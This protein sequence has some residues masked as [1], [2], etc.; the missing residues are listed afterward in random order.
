MHSM[1]DAHLTYLVSPKCK[2]ELKTD[3]VEGDDTVTKSGSLVCVGCGGMYPIINHI[4][5][6]VDKGNY[7]DSFGFEWLAHKKTQ[8]Y[9]A[10]GIKA[11][12]E[13][14]VKETRLGDRLDRQ[15]IIEA[16]SGSG[17]FTK[18]ALQTGAFVI[19]F[20]YSQAAEA[21]FESNGGNNNLLLV[22][23]SIY[24]MPFADD[25]ADKIFCFGVL[26][27]TPSTKDS[28]NTLAKKMK[29]GG[30]LVCDHYPYNENMPFNTKYWVRPITKRLPHIFL[31]NFGKR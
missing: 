25:V 9:H 2:K 15:I 5:L 12:E 3:N 21:N 1:F 30:E 26:Q 6:F 17:R 22:Q 13:R 14:F 10:G 31:Y 23:A 8:Y 29:K 19:S 28:I 20:D 7:A 11:S 27:H 18:H 24:E 16:G 4:P